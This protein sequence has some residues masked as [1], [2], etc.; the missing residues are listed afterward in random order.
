MK[1]QLRNLPWKYKLSIVAVLPLLMAF[2]AIVAFYYASEK[3]ANNVEVQL[4]ES[5]SRQQAA[6]TNLSAVMQMQVVLQ[7]LIA[8][9]SKED[10][11]SFAIAS[12]RASSILDEKIQVLKDAI[13]ER[14]DVRELETSLADVKP[15]QMKIISFAKKNRDEEAI[16]AFKTVE[17][18]I[19]SIADLSRNI[20]TTEQE[21]LGDLAD[22]NRKYGRSIM[23]YVAGG[24]LIGAFATI[25]VAAAYTKQLL[26]SI[27]RI[28]EVMSEFSEGNLSPHVDQG[29]TGEF[30]NINKDIARSIDNIRQ[31][32]V[33][34][35]EEANQ[36]LNDSHSL[37]DTSASN[38]LDADDVL[39][40]SVAMVDRAQVL[41]RTSGETKNRLQECT[42][43]TAQSEKISRQATHHLDSGVERFN[44][45][46]IEM[47]E[48][49]NSSQLLSSS[50]DQIQSITD[51][52]R[53]I[54]EQTNLLALNAAIEAA[55]A[56][57]QG[58]G[59]AVV[60]D[61]VR[62]L[63][64]RSSEA[65]EQV[66]HITSTIHQAVTNT[67]EKLK[68]AVELIAQSLEAMT[69]ASK[70][71]EASTS[72][73]HQC[74][75]IISEVMDA[76]QEGLS[77][78]ASITED[79]QS[80]STNIERSKKQAGELNVMSKNLEKAAVRMAT[81]VEH[82]SHTSKNERTN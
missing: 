27:N 25:L 69:E 12:L 19:E 60:A 79:S 14:Q 70:S 43:I 29:S 81:S 42:S 76:T 7:A 28:R 3:Q 46:T 52:I 1:Y 50:A 51:S 80:I 64:R 24:L 23:A 82:F 77:S 58:R 72:L 71:S 15:F 26:Q 20:L 30:I 47:S 62:N 39:G 65:T 57:D 41:L 2:G 31:V 8:A 54:S 33:G 34:I 9:E 78:L 75:S 48:L 68:N 45:L 6:A 55:R 35:C 4:D 18:K 10:I 32:I 37:S 44:L 11:R 17:H 49:E 61:E 63:A 56:G 74:N 40:N 53:A 36:L 5:K 66:T 38:L 16:E 67:A 59:F 21:L 22:A 13:P 73:A